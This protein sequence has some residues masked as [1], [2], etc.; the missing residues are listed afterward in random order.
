MCMCAWVSTLYTCECILQK[1]CDVFFPSAS[2]VPNQHI[3]W[4]K[5]YLNIDKRI[6]FQSS[7][8]ECYLP[9]AKLYKLNGNE[10]GVKSKPNN[11]FPVKFGLASCGSCKVYAINAKLLFICKKHWTHS[12]EMLLHSILL[13][14]LA[15]FHR[16]N[17]Y[18]CEWK[19]NRTTEKHTSINWIEQKIG[20]CFINSVFEG[21]P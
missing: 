9:T 3:K 8:A 15:T 1:N 11:R 10:I 4:P 6:K 19:A 14:N 20:I 16:N 18:R 12:F 13:N 2:T 7:L 21:F 17:K 5:N